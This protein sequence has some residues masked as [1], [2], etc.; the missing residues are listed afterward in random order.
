[1]FYPQRTAKYC[2]SLLK[3]LEPETFPIIYSVNV[4]IHRLFGY[5]MRKAEGRKMSANC[6]LDYTRKEESFG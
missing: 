3:S 1:M 4:I 2:Y 5:R 6:V